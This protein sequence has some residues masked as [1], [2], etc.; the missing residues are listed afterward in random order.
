MI[1]ARRLTLMEENAKY[2]ISLLVT[3]VLGS[4][5]GIVLQV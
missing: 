5:G 4:L 2:L 3:H 1:K